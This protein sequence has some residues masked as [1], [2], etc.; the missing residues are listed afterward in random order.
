MLLC[1]HLGVCVARIA[2]DCAGPCKMQSSLE[3]TYTWTPGLHPL[4]PGVSVIGGPG[5]LCPGW[6]ARN[7][8]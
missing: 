1:P 3:I 4:R 7:Y 5:F 2:V 8:G 6:P